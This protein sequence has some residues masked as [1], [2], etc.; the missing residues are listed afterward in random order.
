MIRYPSKLLSVARGRHASDW[1]CLIVGNLFVVSIIDPEQL[2][3]NDVARAPTSPAEL[4]RTKHEVCESL[5][6]AL[7]NYISLPVSTK[8]ASLITYVYA[9]LQP[10]L[11]TCITPLKP[12]SLFSQ[13]AAVLWIALCTAPTCALLVVLLMN[14]S[15]E[16]IDAMR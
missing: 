15:V 12:L 3:A 16:G 9:K 2:R 11:G 4:S 5:P 10:V 6:A 13:T 8:S 1:S 14:V 7:V